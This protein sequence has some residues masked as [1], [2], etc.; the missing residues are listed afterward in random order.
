[1]EVETLLNPHIEW[2]VILNYITQ[3]NNKVLEDKSNETVK[4]HRLGRKMEE[5][6][7]KF[8]SVVELDQQHGE[9]QQRLSLAEN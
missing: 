2:T 9:P 6:V 4:F 5:A 1:M 8:R 3:E 7:S